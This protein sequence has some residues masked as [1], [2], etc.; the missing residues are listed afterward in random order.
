MTPGLYDSVF[1]FALA[2]IV[3]DVCVICCKLGQG[4]IWCARVL[5]L[6]WAVESEGSKMY[7]LKR[8]KMIFH[9]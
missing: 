1:V 5:R 3:C 2:E 6:P 7:T 9:D 8:K 4:R